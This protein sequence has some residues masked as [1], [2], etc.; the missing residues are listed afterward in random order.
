MNA[1]INNRSDLFNR[2]NDAGEGYAVGADDDNVNDLASEIGG[3]LVHAAT[4]SDDIAV[5]SVNGS[6]VLVGYSNGP[7]AVAV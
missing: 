3:T 1:I 6:A 7:W 4:T 5:Y 2:F